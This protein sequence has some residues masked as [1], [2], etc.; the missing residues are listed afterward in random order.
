MCSVRSI[1]NDTII[2]YEPCAGGN[3]LD[4]TPCG[5]DTGPGG[6]AYDSKQSL[7][8]H[9]YCPFIQTDVPITNDTVFNNTLLDLCYEVNDLQ[10]YWRLDDT[11]RLKTAGFLTEFGAV[12][13]TKLGWTMIN[14]M[15]DKCDENLV[16]WT[17]WYMNLDSENDMAQI[18]HIT[19]TYAYQVAST[20]VTKMYYNATSEYFRLEYVLMED[21]VE[22]NL[23]TRIYFSHELHYPTGVT[24]NVSP[25]TLVDV[26]V[27]NDNN[28]NTILVFELFFCF[29]FLFCFFILSSHLIQLFIFK[30]NSFERALEYK[31]NLISYQ[32]VLLLTISAISTQ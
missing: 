20:N 27:D 28:S 3:D 7:S 16:S 19:R 4:A 30:C 17:Y 29:V 6:D 9:I 21:M 23:T 14:Y 32:R 10:W 8:Y 22:K 25:D 26:V 18:P 13:Y 12:P 2:F 31:C 15:A 1:D 24:W 5:F 11:K